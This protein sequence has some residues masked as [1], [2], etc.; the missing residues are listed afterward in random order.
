[1]NTTYIFVLSFRVSRTISGEY[2]DIPAAVSY[3]ILNISVNIVTIYNLCHCY[4]T[5]EFN[6]APPPF[7]S[8]YMPRSYSARRNARCSVRPDVLITSTYIMFVFFQEM[9]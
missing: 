3:T 1:M 9:A 8:A 5:T 7:P 4:V 6:A 2:P